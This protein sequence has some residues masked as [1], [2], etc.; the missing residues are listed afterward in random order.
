MFLQEYAL[1]L[2]GSCKTPPIYMTCTSHVYHDAFA[3]A[4]V[5]AVVGTP[6][7][8][9][10]LMADKSQVLIATGE[11]AGRLLAVLATTRVWAETRLSETDACGGSKS[12]CLPFRKVSENQPPLLLKE[13]LQHTGK[14]HSGVLSTMEPKRGSFFTYSGS[15][16]AYSWSFFAYSPLRPLLDALSDCNQ[17]SSNCKPKS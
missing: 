15:C 1:L 4:S 11:H 16:F 3:D 7:S 9:V 2:V 14:G 12:A 17:R 5:S 8:P 10:C 13:V 6:Q